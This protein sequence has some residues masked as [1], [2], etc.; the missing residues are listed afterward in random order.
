MKLSNNPI[1]RL[2]AGLLL[3]ITGFYMFTQKAPLSPT[4]QSAYASIR[5]LLVQKA[6]YYSLRPDGE[7]SGGVIIFPNSNEDPASYA[8]MAKKLAEQ[9]LEIRVVKYPFGF[10]KLSGADRKILEDGNQLSWVSL[11]FGSGVE[12]ACSLADKSALVA[13]LM[14]TGSCNSKVNLNDNDIQVTVYELENEP[15]APDKLAE[16]RKRLPADT[17]FITVASKQEIMTEIPTDQMRIQKA[18]QSQILV[19]EIKRVLW[20][21]VVNSRNKK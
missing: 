12:K 1:I 4:E 8:P 15:F 2:V 19:S 14:I 11:G 16:M 3:L 18:S 9:G 13:G 7:V 6:D 5:P 21:K 20:N 10:I 17:E